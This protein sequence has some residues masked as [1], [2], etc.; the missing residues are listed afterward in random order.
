M[1][2]LDQLGWLAI[3]PPFMMQSLIEMAEAD[4][5]FIKGETFA[6]W[7]GVSLVAVGF[8]VVCLYGWLLSIAQ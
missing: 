6:L 7:C 5:N 8:G 4:Q 3:K 1:R 2:Q